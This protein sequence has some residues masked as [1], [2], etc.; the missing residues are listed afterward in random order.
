MTKEEKI[1]ILKVRLRKLKTSP[2]AHDAPGVIR[3]VTRQIRKLE[4]K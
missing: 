1:Q 4:R 3:K 2:T